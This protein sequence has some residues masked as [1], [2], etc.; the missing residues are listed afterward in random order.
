MK[1]TTWMA[2]L[3]GVALVLGSWSPA[4][5]Q[6]MDPELS[7]LLYAYAQAYCREEWP[8]LSEIDRWSCEQFGISGPG[9]SPPGWTFNDMHRRLV[10]YV[11]GKRQMSFLWEPDYWTDIQCSNGGPKGPQ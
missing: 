11:C 5:A 4:A 10:A 6:A 3:I 7:K 2:A 9:T 8:S 1:C